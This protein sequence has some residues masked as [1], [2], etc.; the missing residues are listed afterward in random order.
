MVN[1]ISEEVYLGTFVFTKGHVVLQLICIEYLIVNFYY[2]APLCPQLRKG[3]RCDRRSTSS[4]QEST[5]IAE[6]RSADLEI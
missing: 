3:H 1:P 6:R 5:A 2:E 4:M